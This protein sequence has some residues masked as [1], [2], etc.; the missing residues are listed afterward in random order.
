MAK[1]YVV[2]ME[3]LGKM[4]D[5]VEVKKAWVTNSA[6]DPKTWELLHE[7]EC[8]AEIV[9]L[10]QSE[11]EDGDFEPEDYADATFGVQRY[12]QRVIADLERVCGMNGGE[13]A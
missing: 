13:Q 1:N 5:E 12:L 2:N 7:L 6:H 9:G 3:E 8:A 11:L 10:I 4:N